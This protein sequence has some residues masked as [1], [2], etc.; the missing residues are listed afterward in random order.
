[1][2]QLL[3]SM[4]AEWR[5]DSG[6]RVTLV[7]CNRHEEDIMLR[8]ALEQLATAFG[9]R[10][11]LW[12][13]LSQPPESSA[14]W[15]GDQND[16]STAPGA[17]GVRHREGRLDARLVAQSLAWPEKDSAKLVVGEEQV[18]ALCCGPEGFNEVA[19]AGLKNLGVPAQR[20]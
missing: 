19:A 16:S 9:Q 5:K 13:L 14:S 1:M 7:F 2:I 10:F 3:K 8:S 11:R 18:V 17:S 4:V 20:V 12:F 15:R 6:V